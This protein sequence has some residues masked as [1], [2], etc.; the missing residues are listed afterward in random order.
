MKAGGATVGAYE[1]KVFAFLTHEEHANDW[2]IIDVPQQGKN[3]YMF[4]ETSLFLPIY[5]DIVALSQ[6]C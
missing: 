4:V 5:A 3:C 1:G 6:H 2:R